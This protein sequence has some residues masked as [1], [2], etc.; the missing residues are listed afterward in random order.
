MT[1]HRGLGSEQWLWRE[2]E[3]WTRRA[4]VLLPARYGARFGKFDAKAFGRVVRSRAREEWVKWGKEY[5]DL[6]LFVSSV[7]YGLKRALKECCDDP[8]CKSIQAA[9]MFRLWKS[10]LRPYILD[11]ID[12]RLKYRE[13]SSK[14]RMPVPGFLRNVNK[15]LKGV[16][17]AERA[18]NRKLDT[19]SAKEDQDERNSSNPD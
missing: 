4:V 18:L 2:L 1:E 14:V 17:D 3:R 15:E 9:A 5:T 8:E 6:D 12:D 7:A 16:K 19:L 10:K 13:Q 11:A